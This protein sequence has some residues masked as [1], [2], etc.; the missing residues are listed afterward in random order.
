[1]QDSSPLR[2][3]RSGSRAMTVIALVLVTF[4]L[5]AGRAVFV[6][7]ALALLLAVA[8][9]PVT[10]L[11]QRVGFPRVAAVLVV[12]ILTIATV[13]G[14][15]LMVAGQVVQLAATLPDYEAVLREKIGALAPGDDVVGRAAAG[16][17]RLEEVLSPGAASPEAS[18]VVA[19][20]PPSP[21]STIT[22]I[23]AAIFSPLASLAVALLLMAFL[24]IGRE[25]ARDRLL[26]L[27]GTRDLH[28]TTRAMSDATQR[29]SRYLLMQLIVNATFGTSMALGLWGIGLPNA[30]LWG[31]LCFS[32]R[33]VPYLGGP[34][35]A[36]F[37][38]IVA[39]LT[40]EG[41]LSVILVIAWFAFVDIVCTYVLEPLLY[42]RSVGISPL[43]LIIAS[44]FWTVVWGPVGLILAPPITACLVIIGR[45]VPAWQALEI[46]FSDASP[47]AA[48]VRFYQRFLAG[49]VH[50]AE[51]VAEEVQNDRGTAAVI[52]TL[53]LP[54]L[55]S[56]RDDRIAGS[57]VTAAAAQIADQVAAVVRGLSGEVDAEGAMSDKPTIAIAPVATALDQAAAE[58]TIAYLRDVGIHAA[59]LSRDVPAAAAVILVAIDAPSPIRLRRA[60]SMAQ[61][62]EAKPYLLVPAGGA[63]PDAD[64]LPRGLRVIHSLAALAATLRDAG[65]PVVPDA[66]AA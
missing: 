13:G 24:L 39:L 65:S 1:M 62:I 46:L 66:A 37:P 55:E 9:F 57:I 16:L 56:L 51:V 43:A 11:L 64:K 63:L 4:G 60:A 34:L 8:L 42:G 14:V 25:D 40:T 28:R 54:A 49:D 38:L 19:M 23:A 26:R 7:L 48:P 59:V 27:A 44:A 61:R 21:L 20:P 52:E 35:S 31:V 45:H 50:G 18:A 53:V 29:V 41:W 3:L 10:N 36:V 33:F 2:T 32:L 5:Y 30:P 17:K 22:T 6:P 47:L 58:A 15:L 12:L